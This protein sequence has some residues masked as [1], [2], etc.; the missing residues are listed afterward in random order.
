MATEGELQEQMTRLQRASVELELEEQRL[1]KA[2]QPLT[3]AAAAGGATGGERDYQSQS[4]STSKSSYSTNPY[5]SSTSGTNSSSSYST[6]GTSGTSGT[7]TGSSSSST[8]TGLS[9][10]TGISGSRSGSG[11]YMSGTYN[12]TGS[13]L[14][15]TGTGTGTG[16]GSA[17]SYT[18]SYQSQSQSGASVT[19]GTGSQSYSSTSGTGTRTGT[20]TGT[21]YTGTSSGTGTGSQSYS[22]TSGTD[23]GTGTSYTGTSSGT[24]TGS[25]SYSSNS[26]TDTGTGSGTGTGTSYTGTS[27]YSLPSQQAPSLANQQRELE[28][29]GETMMLQQRE[30]YE[31]MRAKLPSTSPG[32]ASKARTTDLLSSTVR[33]TGVDESEIDRQTER[34]VVLDLTK[35]LHTR[36]DVA[37]AAGINS[38]SPEGLALSAQLHD[39][40]MMESNLSAIERKGAKEGVDQDTI[41]QPRVTINT[42]PAQQDIDQRDTVNVSVQP[43]PG[44]GGYSGKK[45]DEDPS[46]WSFPKPK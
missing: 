31:E 30:R 23:T 18:S 35:G 27:S 17:S 33:F 6:G 15:G 22:S 28:A 39:L 20:G 7:R 38:D 5:V 9:T 37:N 34:E 29:T 26:G 21:S 43:A 41:Y 36:L 44:G 24:G 19:T 1:I 32:S 14:T 12:G 45:V 11:G 46:L 13:Q 3:G 25:Q 40:R 4:S 42:R 2:Q 16:S 10:G 8:G